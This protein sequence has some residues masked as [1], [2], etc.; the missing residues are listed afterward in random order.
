MA[1]SL[2]TLDFCPPCPE[3]DEHVQFNML[4]KTH[5]N[6]NVWSDCTQ[7]EVKPLCHKSTNFCKAFI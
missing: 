7:T 3:T 5:G 4:P 2:V 6:K 1:L